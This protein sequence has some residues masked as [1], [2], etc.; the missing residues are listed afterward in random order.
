M[1]QLYDTAK[2]LTPLQL[3]ELTNEHAQYKEMYSNDTL[4]RGFVMKRLDEIPAVKQELISTNSIYD[5][6]IDVLT[7]KGYDITDSAIITS[8]RSRSRRDCA[9]MMLHREIFERLNNGTLFPPIIYVVSH[10]GEIRGFFNN[11]LD[12]KDTVRSAMY[13]SD[14][15]YTDKYD[16]V[17]ADSHGY[18]ISRHIVDEDHMISMGDLE[19]NLEAKATLNEFSE[20]KFIA[21]GNPQANDDPQQTLNDLDNMD[22]LAFYA[23]QYDDAES[24][25]SIDDIFPF[26]NTF[27]GSENDSLETVGRL[28]RVNHDRVKMALICPPVCWRLGSYWSVC[29]SRVYPCNEESSKVEPKEY[30][31]I[32]TSKRYASCSMRSVTDEGIVSKVRNRFKPTSYHVYFNDVLVVGNSHTAIINKDIEDLYMLPMNT[33]IDRPYYQ[34]PTAVFSK[35]N[36]YVVLIAVGNNPLMTISYNKDGMD[37]IS[38]AKILASIVACHLACKCL[39]VEALINDLYEAKLATDSP[40][41]V[42]SSKMGM[43]EIYNDIFHKRCRAENDREPL[44]PLLEHHNHQV[45]E[46]FCAT[47]TYDIDLCSALSLYFGFTAGNC[48]LLDSPVS[49]SFENSLKYTSEKMISHNFAVEALTERLIDASLCD[50]PVKVVL[51]PY[52]NNM[53]LV[54][55]YVVAECKCNACVNY[56]VP[57]ERLMLYVECNS[58]MT[59]ISPWLANVYESNILVRSDGV[60]MISPH[61]AAEKYSTIWSV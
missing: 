18:T 43:L 57:A 31:S 53:I 61:Q 28:F 10:R 15:T 39:S 36:E 26:L 56:C 25:E 2:F 3:A 59:S 37:P 49:A 50:E 41:C 24:F 58:H 46:G 7:S 20:T 13:K 17:I 22:I 11:Y 44:I 38:K 30:V 34:A 32:D 12:A 52:M 16:N 6:I 42:C 14:G 1:D 29:P 9:P 8:P 35:L 40:S 27:A 4:W 54:P 60:R 21:I 51:M 19:A 55:S 48:K 23:G 47:P 45:E 33:F 5:I